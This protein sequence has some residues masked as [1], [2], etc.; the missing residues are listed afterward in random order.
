MSMPKG[1]A[2]QDKLA[3]FGL[4]EFYGLLKGAADNPASWPGT[5]KLSVDPEDSD[6][7]RNLLYAALWELGV[8]PQFSIKLD[9]GFGLRVE[10]RRGTG[11]MVGVN[12]EGQAASGLAR[13][14][15]VLGDEGL[16]DIFAP[17][18]P[19]QWSPS[20]QTTTLKED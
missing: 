19:G 11:R 9:P 6:Y 3:R 1:Q 12:I 14:G 10:Q 5:A 20:R 15:D 2:L 16:A 4:A 18:A 13:P 17:D 7:I 8:K